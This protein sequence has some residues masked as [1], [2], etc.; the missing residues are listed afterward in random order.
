VRQSKVAPPPAPFFVTFTSLL[1]IDQFLL[2]IFSTD[3]WYR[4]GRSQTLANQY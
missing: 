3:N 1:F 2:F 4:N